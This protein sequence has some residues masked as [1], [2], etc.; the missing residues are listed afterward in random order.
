VP[1][2]IARH[3]QPRAGT[4]LKADHFHQRGC[5]TA[6][7]KCTPHILDSPA[8]SG[9][10]GVRMAAADLVCGVHFVIA[11]SRNAAV[12][13]RHLRLVGQTCSLPARVSTSTSHVYTDVARRGAQ[14]RAHGRGTTCAY[15]SLAL[16]PPSPQFSVLHTTLPGQNAANAT[17][18]RGAYA[19]IAW[20]PTPRSGAGQRVTPTALVR[21]PFLGAALAGS[22]SAAPTAAARAMSFM[23]A[24]YEGASTTFF[25]LCSW[26]KKARHKVQRLTNPMSHWSFAGKARRWQ[27]TWHCGGSPPSPPP[28]VSPSL[29]PR[30]A[31]PTDG[32]AD[33]ELPVAGVAAPHSGTALDAPACFPSAAAHRDGEGGPTASAAGE[34]LSRKSGAL[35]SLAPTGST[36]WRAHAPDSLLTGSAEEVVDRLE[37]IASSRRA[38]PSIEG[39]CSV[40]DKI[41]AMQLLREEA[42]AWEQWSESELATWT[43]FVS[44]QQQRTATCLPTASPTPLYRAQSSPCHFRATV[45]ERVDTATQ[46]DRRI[47]RSPSTLALQQRL[48]YLAGSAAA[49]TVRSARCTR[50]SVPE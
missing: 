9:N 7:S 8:R 11:L 26:H 15:V 40:A 13:T 2:H 10:R 21:G 19:P 5:T 41:E 39:S 20:Q 45:T 31:P 34:L 22:M 25:F 27:T 1:T 46:S 4:E 18:A 42:R 23:K 16:I 35:D 50:C 37:T 32:A 33:P 12:R 49:V 38:G 3:R 36:R 44:T 30:S 6:T 28:A 24:I 29:E 17:R 48:A 47:R 43:P 14:K